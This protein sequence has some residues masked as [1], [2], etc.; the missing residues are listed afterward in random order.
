M[1]VEKAKKYNTTKVMKCPRCRITS[2]HTL[3]DFKY[4]IYK[5]TQC[6]NIHV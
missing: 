4:A 2:K 1:T 3:V 5:C 6:G